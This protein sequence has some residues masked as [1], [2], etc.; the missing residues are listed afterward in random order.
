MV[1]RALRESLGF[2]SAEDPGTAQQQQLL[3]EHLAR[4]SKLKSC[5]VDMDRVMVNILL[6]YAPAIR[7][8][9]YLVLQMPLVQRL[10]RSRALSQ[11]FA[12]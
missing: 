9:I 10:L 8:L 1:D 11:V 7:H 3:Q 2:A 4:M 5:E 6:A 12:E